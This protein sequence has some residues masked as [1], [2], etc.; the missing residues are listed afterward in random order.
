MDQTGSCLVWRTQW[1]FRQWPLGAGHASLQ[2]ICNHPEVAE[3]GLQMLFITDH[4]GPTTVEFRRDECSGRMVLMEVNARTILGQQMITQSGLDVPLMACH[5]AIGM[6][7]PAPGRVRP[8]RCL[9]VQSDFR[10]FGALRELGQLTA[11]QWLGSLVGCRAFAYFAL[12]DSKPF[13][14]DLRHWLFD[15]LGSSRN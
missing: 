4:R 15:A 13:L 11:W 12:G 2:E 10:S 3:S 5:G 9:H 7:L 1:K 14:R 6:H 8:V